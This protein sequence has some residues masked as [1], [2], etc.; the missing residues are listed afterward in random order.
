MNIKFKIIIIITFILSIIALL[1]S[2]LRIIDTTDITGQTYIGILATFIGIAVTIIVGAQIFNSIESKRV[3]DSYEK[4]V[5]L[6]Q[7]DIDDSKI[8]IN[9]LYSVSY[10]IEAYTK[11]DKYWL[12]SIENYFKAVYSALNANDISHAKFYLS[13]LSWKIR[14]GI[15]LVIEKKFNLLGLNSSQEVL[16]DNQLRLIQSHTYFQLIQ[17]EFSDVLSNWNKF[18]IDLESNTIHY[19]YKEEKSNDNSESGQDKKN[20]DKN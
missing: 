9:Y 11:E 17:T 7:K 16:I 14:D 13:I 3:I 6:I 12:L 1:S 18:K 19:N 10:Y 8:K 2:V 4:K 5:K 20:P 15:L